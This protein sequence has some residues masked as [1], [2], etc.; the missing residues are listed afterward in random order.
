MNYV[1]KK[2]KLKRMDFFFPRR[3]TL[4]LY[5]F[6][7]YTFFNPRLFSFIFGLLNFFEITFWHLE[8]DFEKS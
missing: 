2:L 7:L 6:Q 3:N 5:G 8:R 1:N 4:I